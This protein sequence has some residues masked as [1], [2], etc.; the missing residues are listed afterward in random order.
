MKKACETSDVDASLKKKRLKLATRRV[1]EI[2]QVEDRGHQ[3]NFLAPLQGATLPVSA[4][5]HAVGQ[6]HKMNL[7]A[8]RLDGNFI[9]PRDPTAHPSRPSVLT[10]GWGRQAAPGRR[11]PEVTAVLPVWKRSLNGTSPARARVAPD[12][13]V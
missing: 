1:S 3:L 7:V 4:G 5:P 10:M 2:K 9:P 8:G 12:P 6:I 11:A 13:S